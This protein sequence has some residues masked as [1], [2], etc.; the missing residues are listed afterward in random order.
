MEEKGD[1][2]IS[3]PDIDHLVGIYVP[4]TKLKRRAKPIDMYLFQKAMRHRSYAG[5][6][7]RLG[8]YERLEYLGDAVYHAI[9]SSYV[10]ARFNDQKA[11]ILTDIRIKMECSGTMASLTECLHLDTFVRSREE[12]TQ[13]VLEDVYEAFIGAFYLNY[14]FEITYDFVVAV[15][16]QH[17]D[18]PTL[19]SKEKNYKGVIVRYFHRKEWPDPVYEISTKKHEGRMMIYAEL[20]NNLGKVIGK[21]LGTTDKRAEQA[22]SKSALKKL[23]ILVDDEIIVGWE[24]KIKKAEKTKIITKDVDEMLAIFNPDNILINIT[25]VKTILQNY[26]LR[27]GQEKIDIK[28]FREASTHSSY[29]KRKDISKKERAASV[30]CVALQKKSNESLQFLGDAFNRLFLSEF[31]Y[32]NYPDSQEGELST[33]RA[34]MEG[35]SVLADLA[36]STEI[37]AFLLVGTVVEKIHGRTAAIKAGAYEAFLGALYLNL[38]YDHCRMFASS[39]VKSEID[40]EEIERQN[41]NY[42]DLVKEWC[43]RY[44]QG[45]VSY[46]MISKKGPDH[47]LQFKYGL[48]IQGEL[49]A[50]GRGSARKMAEQNAARKFWLKNCQE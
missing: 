39:V 7:S 14:G 23:G 31:L 44:D 41:V 43:R 38:G 19:I 3:Y 15:I 37:G 45:L 34:R 4:K 9:I 21:G 13:D 1:G 26:G 49:V 50:I 6:H 33:L 47:A 48:S 5:N 18:I 32:N 17:V 46:Q 42:K 27:L 25:A 20:S 11:G 2:I 10:I 35:R 40:M 24:E 12:I 8:N 30:G 36:D 28:L 22:A 29:V 16:E